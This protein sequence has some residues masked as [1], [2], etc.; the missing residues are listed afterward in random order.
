MF[1]NRPNVCT[2]DFHTTVYAS[3][4]LWFSGLTDLRPRLFFLRAPMGV[5]WSRVMLGKGPPTA[6]R[7][8]S[9]GL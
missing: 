2:P 3:F 8:C 4:Q 5:M 9:P 7:L 1:S 6:A